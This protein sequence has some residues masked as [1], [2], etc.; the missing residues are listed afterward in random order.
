MPHQASERAIE[1]LQRLLDL[2]SER[3]VTTLEEL[4]NQVAAS[5]P[6]ALHRG[7]ASGKIRAGH[8]VALVG[9]GAGLS[10]GGAVLSF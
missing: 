10:F 2:P 6:I 3:F 1:H 8:T 9:S 5:L 7:I 4:G